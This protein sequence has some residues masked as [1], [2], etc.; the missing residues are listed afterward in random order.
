M[1]KRLVFILCLFVLLLPVSVQA[2]EEIRL[3][4]LQVDLWPEYDRP[5]ML[6]IYRVQLAGD[7]SMPAEV[8]FRI[9]AA[10]G[11]PNAVAVRQPDGA[12]LNAMH[13]QQTEGLWTY[14]T[15]TATAPEIQLE[16]YDPQIEKQD[17]DRS[18]EFTW[19]SD[20]DVEAMLILVQQPVGANGMSIEPDLGEFTPGSDGLQYYSMEV[21]APLAGDAVSVKVNYQKDDD[22]LS[23]DA[24]QVQPSAPIAEGGQDL[25][26]V[27]LASLLPWFLGGLGV[28]LVVG[29]IL[30]YWRA[31]QEPS[32]PKRASRGGRSRTTAKSEADFRDTGDAKYCHQC[33]KRAADG[34]R[35]C[36]TCGA[37]LRTG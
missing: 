27:N 1:S 12:L 15:V 21:G 2:Q 34:D 11:A 9:P 29:G 18:F 7:V 6:V 36:R 35:F 13:D 31:G 25:T 19:L 24:F 23:I 30:W 3:S 10:A 32:A 28:L 20:Y 5:E 4:N 22:S 37:R 8:T 16:Y 26:Q 33:G 14:I 17:A